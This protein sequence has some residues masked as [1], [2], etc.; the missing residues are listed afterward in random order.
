MLRGSDF[1]EVRDAA[2]RSDEEVSRFAAARRSRFATISPG[3]IGGV[4]RQHPCNSCC[5]RTLR[6]DFRILF[7]SA[8]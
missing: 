4:T 6:C 7:R 3:F 2:M 1:Q 8:R 5:R